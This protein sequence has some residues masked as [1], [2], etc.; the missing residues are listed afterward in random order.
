L[1]LEHLDRLFLVEVDTAREFT[2]RDDF[3]QPIKVGRRWFWFP[4]E[5]LAW[6]RQ[7]P[8]FSVAQRKRTPAP[9]PAP[10]AAHSTYTRRTPKAGRTA[11]VAA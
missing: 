9:A 1:A 5:V 6:T 8:R 11:E 3:P 7:Q 4:E 2:Y 10:A